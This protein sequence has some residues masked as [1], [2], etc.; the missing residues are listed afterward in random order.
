MVS[1]TPWTIFFDGFMCTQGS[2]IGI[3]IISPKGVSYEFAFQLGHHHTN[4][5]AEYEALVKGMLL[6]SYIGAEVME[7]F[8]DSM[9]V[10]N[11]M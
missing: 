1:V 9:L 8:R 2:E 7:I 11:Q 5:Q 4:N 6:L 10:V 3:I